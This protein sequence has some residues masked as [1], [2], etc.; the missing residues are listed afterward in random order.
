MT[1]LTSGVHATPVDFGTVESESPFCSGEEYEETTSDSASGSSTEGD[2]ECSGSGDDDEY[3]DA[4][5]LIAAS[6]APRAALHA[7]SSAEASATPDT[8]ANSKQYF[9]V[10]A[11]FPGTQPTVHFSV[12]DAGVAGC[13]GGLGGPDRCRKPAVLPKMFLKYTGVNTNVIKA[14]FARAGFRKCPADKDH[15]NA[16]WASPLPST[17]F[18]GLKSYQKVNHFPGTWE[19][20]RK[21]KLYRNVAKMRRRHGDAYDV[22]PCAFELPGS[23]DEFLK[24]FE[25]RPNQ[26]Y[27][28]KPRSS[29]RGRGIRMLKRLS[30]VRHRNGN[31]AP[32]EC[33]VQR[34]IKNPLLIGGFK[35]DMR[36][37][38]LVTC[39]DPL[40]VYLSTEGLARFA[41]EP[42][43][44]DNSRLKVRRAHLTNVSVNS[45]SSK[46]VAN[47][48]AERDG[49]GSK[50]T[51][52]ALRRH[53]EG[54]MGVAW[55]PI[56]RQIKDITVKAVISADAKVNTLIKMVCQCCDAMR[57]E[58]GREGREEREGKGREGRMP[59]GQPP[60]SHPQIVPS[61]SPSPSLSVP[62]AK[63]PNPIRFDPIRSNGMPCMR[64]WCKHTHTFTRTSLLLTLPLPPPSLSP[65][66]HSTCPA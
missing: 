3:D 37:Y 36:I 33:L 46:F 47:V 19:L 65:S 32:R 22:V 44:A 35:F 57:D 17:R 20:G 18:K 50:W 7:P 9:V 5:E 13:E 12:D 26:F 6:E 52:H 1:G 48:D 11:T 58:K 59:G 61:P 49:E 40:R 56:W 25:R 55:E 66:P 30:D 34:Y 4:A 43:S 62:N 27:I 60:L 42:Y 23:Y 41:T 24:D 2:L 21:D 31:G 38:M 28:I 63:P 16:Y 64:M 54:T 10:D 29:S 8:G 53:L 39:F 51:L 45:K 15:F 14:A